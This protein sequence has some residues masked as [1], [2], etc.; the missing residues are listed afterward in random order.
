MLFLSSRTIHKNKKVSIKQLS[1]FLVIAHSTTSSLAN[2]I[3]ATIKPSHINE[4]QVTLPTIQVAAIQDSLYLPNLYA[5]GQIARITQMGIL[6][7]KDYMDSPFSQVGYSSNAIRHQHALSVAETLTTADASVRTTTGSTNRYDALTIRGFRIENDDMALNGLFG[8][9]PAYRVGVDPVER[10]ELTRGA[11]AFLYGMSP[12]GAIGGNVNVVTKRAD[13]QPLRQLTTAYSTDQHLGIHADIGQ[14]FGDN[15]E[16]GLRLN[17]AYRDGDT[18][19]DHQNSRNS[20]HS[21]GLDYH[22]DRLN[23]SADIIYQKDMMSRAVRGLTAIAGIDIPKAPNPKTN[24]SALSD[25]SQAESLTF[26]S[27]AEYQLN[28]AALVYGTVGHNHFNYDKQEVPGLTILN[29]NGDTRADTN[30]QQGHNGTVSAE[31][32]TRIKLSTGNIQHQFVLAA[33]HF[34]QQGWFGQSRYESYLTN[35]YHPTYVDD[36]GQPIAVVPKAKSNETMLRSV[37]FAD[38]LS[39]AQDKLQFTLGLRHQQVETSNFSANGE[40]SNHYNESATTPSFALVYKPFKQLS[41]YANYI[42]ALT[43]GAT[44]PDDAVNFNQVF[45]PYKSKQYELGTKFDLGNFGGTVAIFQIRKPTGIVDPESKIYSLDGEQQNQG[46]ELNGFGNITPTL[47]FL[48]GL[49]FV[50]AKLRRTQDGLNDNHHAVG[51]PQFLSNL[52]LEWDTPFSPQLTLTGRIIH[53]AKAYVSADNSQ[54]VP[55][56]TRFDFGGRYQTKIGKAP[57]TLQANLN[58]VFNKAYWEA[59]PSSYMTISTPR[60]L[61][62]STTFDF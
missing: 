54:S 20:S 18:S 19:I 31:V 41:F 6:G 55:D 30:L 37:V 46:I 40:R 29:P 53:N 1:F 25:Y 21:F 52:G 42:E 3:A 39:T 59:N 47:R 22:A 4:A 38:S 7:N 8:L 32:G 2:D 24:L 10:I 49:S 60:T 57:V 51:V 16:Y 62:L 33:N 27:R 50:D 45:A 9:V 13:K 61:L 15:Q 28:D 23:L 11:G 12:F 36:L 35:I 43:V 34:R 56:W 26:L 44:P 5:G 58:N 14:R 17:T 48:G